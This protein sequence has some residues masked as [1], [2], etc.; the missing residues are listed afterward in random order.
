MYYLYQKRLAVTTDSSLNDLI[1][2]IISKTRV[3]PRV[4][5][6]SGFIA[7][8]SQITNMKTMNF[9]YDCKVQPNIYFT[10]IFILFLFQS[11]IKFYF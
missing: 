1:V 4:K 3:Q 9:E 2:D 6:S 10:A 11:F 7:S 8:F 5:E